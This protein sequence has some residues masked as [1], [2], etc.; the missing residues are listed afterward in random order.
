MVNL[1]L[2][3]LNLLVALDAL[4]AEAHV[5][6]AA[7][8][9]GRSQPAV[10]HSLRRLRELLGDALL[11][12]IGPRMEL[13]PRALGLRASL[14][15]ALERVQSLLAAESFVP[16]TSSRRFQVVIHDHLADLVVPAIVRRMST[17]APRA[18]LEVLPWESPFAM[19]PERLRS[20]D[21][22]TSCSTADL[23][24]FDRRPLFT[25]RD[26]VVARRDHP[27][28]TRLGTM[29]TFAEARH[30]AVTRD[31]LDAWLLKEGV[32]RRIGL[33]V[34]SYLQALHAAAASDLVAFVPR[35]LAEALAAP[36]SLAIVK[37]PIDPGPYQEFLFYPRRRDGD[38]AAR[39]LH[40]IVLAIGRDVDAPTRRRRRT[41][42]AGK[43]GKSRN[44]GSR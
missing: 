4:L 34:P 29:R 10:S 25:D 15:D 14:P 28:V 5:G 35:R 38:G 33:T 20:L 39:W 40:D 30:I 26:V 42:E 11:V 19:T 18:W 8:R 13:T 24:G 17:E 1:A 37:P 12:R 27:L 31:P 22:F 9:I 23:P 41:L 21:L 43:D 44:V 2:V 7:R 6:R 16:A 32:E 3:D 36:L